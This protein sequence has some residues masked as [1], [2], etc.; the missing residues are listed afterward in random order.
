MV[1]P[2]LHFFTNGDCSGELL[3]VNPRA[4]AGEMA[5]KLPLLDD[6]HASDAGS[7]LLDM[8]N[9]FSSEVEVRLG[10]SVRCR[11]LPTD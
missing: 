6:F 2:T 8:D 4:F 7:F 10:K 9:D 1:F 5:Q 11:V 3:P